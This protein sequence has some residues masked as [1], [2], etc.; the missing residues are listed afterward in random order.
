M[1]NPFRVES[2][3]WFIPRVLATLELW[4]RVSERLRRLGG[5]SE[6]LRR[7]GGVSERLRRLGGVTNAFGVFKLKQYRRGGSGPFTS[8]NKLRW[9]RWW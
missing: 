8:L 3:F 6:R 1:P 4:A 7:L 2:L 5:V 9:V